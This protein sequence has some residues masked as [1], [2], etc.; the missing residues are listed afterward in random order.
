MNGSII[1]IAATGRSVSFLFVEDVVFRA[2]LD[3]GVLE[4]LDGVV[5]GFTGEIGISSSHFPLTTCKRDRRA[6]S[7]L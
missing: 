5:G 6:I 4:T 2:S 3:S 7:A 1:N